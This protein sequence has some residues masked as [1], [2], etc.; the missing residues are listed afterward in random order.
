MIGNIIAAIVV[1]AVTL[2]LG[3]WLI[4]GTASAFRSV[5]RGSK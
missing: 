3:R 2:W 4:K 5:F 1:L